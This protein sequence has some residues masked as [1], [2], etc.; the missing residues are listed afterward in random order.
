M[1]SSWK[2]QDSVDSI[3]SMVSEVR[4]LPSGTFSNSR[5]TRNCFIGVRDLPL[6]DMLSLGAWRMA[7]D[8]LGK[9]FRR[10]HHCRR[11]APPGVW[12][13]GGAEILAFPEIKS[14]KCAPRRIFVI[15]FLNLGLQ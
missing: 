3:I 6:R 5:S 11:R 4:C 9:F 13:G 2:R 15:R 14:Q 12:G 8:A 1:P 10:R 7:L